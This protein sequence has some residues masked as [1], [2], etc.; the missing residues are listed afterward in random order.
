MAEAAD[1]TAAPEDDPL[2]WEA[3]NAPRAAAFALVAAILHLVGSV[4]IYVVNRGA[5]SGEG[6]VLTFVDTLGRAAAGRPDP[7]GAKAVIFAY[8]GQH[9][10]LLIVATVLVGLGTLAT[11]PPLAYLYRATRARA[12]VPR[13]ALIASAVGAAGSGIG[14]TVSGI[15][16]YERAHAFTTAADRTNSAVL[17]A[18]SNSV[19]L[20]GAFIGDIVGLGLA[21]AFLLICLNARR[22]GLLRQFMGIVGMFVGATIVLRQLDPFGAVRALWLG[23]LAMLFVGR[24]PMP[25]PK[26]WSVPEAVPWPTAAQVREQREAARRARTG[27]PEPERPARRRGPAATANGDGNEPAAAR[28]SR[29]PAP[30]APQPRRADAAPGKP[31]P[32]SKKRKRKRRS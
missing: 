28:A 23:G 26:A 3:Q 18:Q 24:T 10:T 8:Q 4:T 16:I 25:R 29:V 7:P 5:P 32:S 22:A 12:P 20:A 19:F 2:A 6:R 30:R 31:H 21:V 17:D 15:A 13:F 27:E 1:R 14:L 11:Y 9:A